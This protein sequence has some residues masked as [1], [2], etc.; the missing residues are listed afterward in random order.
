M[1]RRNGENR[2][3]VRVEA[4]SIAQKIGKKPTL[5]KQTTVANKKSAVTSKA[6]S[7]KAVASARQDTSGIPAIVLARIKTIGK[8]VSCPDMWRYL[9]H[10]DAE[11]SLGDVAANAKSP[12]KYDFDRRGQV[13]PILKRMVAN[14]LLSQIAVPSDHPGGA[15][16]L[17]AINTQHKPSKQMVS[18]K[19]AAK[20]TQAKKKA[21]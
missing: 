2:L 11:A 12:T 18:K 8:P 6:Q 3:K 5:S 19:T 9:T 16:A 10:R 20:P 13:R 14:G 21:K 4:P 15:N 1:M 17:Y 7:K